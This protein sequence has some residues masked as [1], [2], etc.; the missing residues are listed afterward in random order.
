MLQKTSQN[1]KFDI[2]K[3]WLLE[4]AKL[5]EGSDIGAGNPK[6]MDELCGLPPGSFEKFREEKDKAL[7]KDEDDRKKRIKLALMEPTL[8]AAA[9]EELAA[10]NP[11]TMDELCGQPSG[12]FE[13]FRLEM[14][15][16]DQEANQSRRMRI[17][18][19]PGSRVKWSKIEKEK[20]AKTDTVLNTKC[21]DAVPESIPVTVGVESAR[22]GRIAGLSHE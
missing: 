8:V 6:T 19:G 2:E 15:N 5:E 10:G 11:K 1:M 4:K 12:A 13:K 9:N 20:A 22:D 7:A 3:E 18:A 17:L 16:L 14:N 21:Y